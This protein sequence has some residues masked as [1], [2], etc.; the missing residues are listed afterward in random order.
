MSKVTLTLGSS[1][2]LYHATDAGVVPATVLVDADGE[3][4]GTSANPLHTTGGG[5]GGGSG[6]TDAQLRASPVPVIV[7][8][9][10]CLKTFSVALTD[11]SQT[12]AQVIGEAIPTGAVTCEIQAQGG[13]IRIKRD[14]GTVTASAGYRLD[15]GVKE[16]VDS[17]LADIRLIR[18]S[19]VTT[20]ANLE[21]FNRV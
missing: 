16:V 21:F 19:A 4:L 2:Q 20:V 10:V 12:L 7:G 8:S 18:Q 14:G 11:T 5:G 13:S 1:P 3:V 17:V 9:R 6:L 15:D